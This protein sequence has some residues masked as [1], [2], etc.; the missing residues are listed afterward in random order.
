MTGRP[1]W[2]VILNGAPRS[3]K[4]SIVRVVQD[5]F[6]GVWMNLGVDVFARQ[7]TPLR[8]Q[9]GIG[10]RPDGE[11][12][13]LEQL[14]PSLY[15]A[16]FESIAAHSRHG[17]NVV[18]DVGI[19]DGYARPRQVLRDAA[20]R[21]A[22]LPALLVG[23]RCPIDVVVDRR[24]EEPQDGTYSASAEVVRRWNEAVHDPAVYDLEVDTSLLSPE[25]CATEIR[26]R[27]ESGRAPT[28]L[29][30]LRTVS[31]R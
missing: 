31:P 1:G 21:L 10:L 5:S 4:T 29:E 6:D 19:H 27:I 22:G 15:A 23:V 3:G 18:V 11:R 25:Q 30:R 20:H 7:V 26:R 17:L 2:I 14:L 16:F 9:P 12:P 24:N 13:E 8:Y 28:A